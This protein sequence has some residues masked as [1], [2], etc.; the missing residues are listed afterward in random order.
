MG[1]SKLVI[2]WASKIASVVDVHLGPLLRDI[3]SIS[4]EWLSF[5]HIYREPNGKFD[6][7]SKEALS[8]PIGAL[9]FYEFINGE[10]TEAMEF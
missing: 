10:E 2:H 8:L 9:G 4:F 3:L 7:L 1:D 6:E 5:R